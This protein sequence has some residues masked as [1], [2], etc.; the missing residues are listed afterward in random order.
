MLILPLW[1]RTQGATLLT[2]RGESEV[3]VWL[4]VTDRTQVFPR[5]VLG[6]GPSARAPWLCSLQ[7]C[8]AVTQQQVQTRV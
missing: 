4:R 1:G 7:G 3:A 6:P 8:K 5:L 2:K